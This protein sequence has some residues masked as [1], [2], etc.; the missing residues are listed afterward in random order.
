MSFIDKENRRE[1]LY[2]AVLYAIGAVLGDLA[3]RNYELAESLHK[4]FGRYIKEYLEKKGLKYRLSNDPQEL[5]GNILKLFIDDLRFAKLEKI[6]DTRDRGKH[7]VWKELL[8]REAYEELAK[9]Y[10]D[11]FLSCPLNA[12]IRYELDKLGYT[13]IV[14]GCRTDPSR[15]ILESWE[16]VVKGTRFLAPKERF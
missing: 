14:H 5:V 1:I 6:E 7:G 9:K 13:L 12:V 11:P 10:P 4:E 3:S 15:D 16:E 8:G 2:N